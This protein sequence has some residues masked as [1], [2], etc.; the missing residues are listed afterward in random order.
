[1]SGRIFS[2]GAGA[3]VGYEFDVYLSYSRQGSVSEWVFNHFF[4]SL[5][6]ALDDEMPYEPRIF[7]DQNMATGLAWP[8]SLERA[9]LRS[10]LMVAVLSA[11]YFRSQWCLAEWMT[12][13]GRERESVATDDLIVP[14]VYAGGKNFPDF[15][16]SRQLVDFKTWSVPHDLFRHS[17]DYLDFHREVR[18]LAVDIAE[19][20][21]TV[22]EWDAAWQ[23]VR[24][25]AVSPSTQ[26]K[27]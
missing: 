3:G 8:L 12:M 14:V 24:P 22:P 13:S 10:R 17:R 16:R 25:D 2:E 7:V 9:L 6:E 27:W 11:P 23:V 1:M 18:R 26:S 5:S 20:L 19:R 21:R 4:P 15:A